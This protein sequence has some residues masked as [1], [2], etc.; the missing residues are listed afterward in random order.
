METLVRQIHSHTDEFRGEY[1]RAPSG[2]H[3]D[4]VPVGLQ[5]RIV[6]MVSIKST[7][8]KGNFQLTL[9]RLAEPDEV[10]LDTDIDENGDL[11]GH[12]ADLLKHKISGGTHPHD[13]HEILVLQEGQPAGFDLGYRLV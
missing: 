7:H 9:T 11:L 12:F 4:N 8:R 10:L 3:R 1:A 2:N 6:R 13:V 5:G